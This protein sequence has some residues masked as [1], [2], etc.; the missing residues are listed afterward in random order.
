MLYRLLGGTVAT[1]PPE[2]RYNMPK[3]MRTSL[4]TKILSGL[5]RCG[6]ASGRRIVLGVSGGADSIAMLDAMVRSSRS[7]LVVAHLNH[8]L[9]GE[10][11]D[12]DEDF[13][14]G[15]A[16]KRDL[17]FE[18]ERAAVAEKAATS[19]RN[20]EAVA[21][22]MRYAFLT[23]V[24]ETHGGDVV[25]TAHTRNDQV[26]T[27]LLRL[28]RGTSPRGLRG[29][30]EQRRLGESVT[31]VRPMLD[32]TRDE[33]L[34]HC[35]HYGLAFRTDSSNLSLTLSRNRVR[36]D[37]LPHLRALNPQFEESLLRTA[38]LIGEDAALLDMLAA[39]QFT[40]AISQ[41]APDISLDA[42]SIRDLPVSIR[43]R[44]IRL[45]LEKVRGD[46]LRIDKTHLDAVDRLI[47]RGLGGKA[48]ELP[49][50][51]LVRIERGILHFSGHT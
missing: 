39:D 50:G 26:E 48:V 10:E 32:S 51:G 1:I 47:M 27:I 19:R 8:C 17:P 45:W 37:L 13:V 15:E 6:I 31:L 35:A 7:S 12:D 9:R 23:R 16:A 4:E 43:S 30:F 24:A 41:G 18:S 11:S 14:R 49:G 21:R 36:H 5:K 40:R 22:E 25:A 44:M 20:I 29:I 33:V 42:K 3:S 28:I 46:L 2:R 38:V 34:E